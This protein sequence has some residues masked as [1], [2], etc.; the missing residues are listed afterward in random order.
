MFVALTPGIRTK[1]PCLFGV[2]LIASPTLCN[3][4][5]S[6]SANFT[7]PLSSLLRI[8]LAFSGE[9]AFNSSFLIADRAAGDMNAACCNALTNLPPASPPRVAARVF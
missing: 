1:P 8:T 9:T 7:T 4:P 2:F 3:S 6:A 5:D